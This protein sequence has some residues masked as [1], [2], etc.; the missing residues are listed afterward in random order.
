MKT[1][2][3]IIGM[4][5]QELLSVC[6]QRGV[7]LGLDIQQPSARIPEK[8]LQVV[9]DFLQSQIERALQSCSDGDHIMISESMTAEF[10]VLTIKN[11]GRTVT[12]EEKLKLTKMGYEVRARYG[13]DTTVA[14]KIAY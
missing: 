7:A 12:A 5:Y 10:I 4:L 9:Y 13:Y 6:E 8:K 1:I 2:A 11:S 14:L 3:D